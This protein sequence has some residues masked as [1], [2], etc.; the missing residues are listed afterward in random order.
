MA[1]LGH[2]IGGEGVGGFVKS[3]ESFGVDGHPDVVAI[4]GHRRDVVSWQL[5][6][7][8]RIGSLLSCLAVVN[9]KT[10]AVESEIK[11]LLRGNDSSDDVVG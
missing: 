8:C 9:F 6:V 3:H 11:L 10:S 5:A 7:G 2:A 1:P 4:V